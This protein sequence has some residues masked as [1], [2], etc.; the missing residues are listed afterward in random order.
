MQ[1][2]IE[3]NVLLYS[4]LFLG[5]LLGPLLFFT[6]RLCN[7]IYHDYSRHRWYQEVGSFFGENRYLLEGASNILSSWITNSLFSTPV[8]RPFTLR[9]N[10][11]P[12]A[13][14]CPYAQTC[15]GP[16]RCPFSDGSR[17]VNA[18]AEPRRPVTPDFSLDGRGNNRRP[19][20]PDFSINPSEWRV[21]GGTSGV[22]GTIGASGT[23][24]TTGGVGAAAS[25]T[26]CDTTTLLNNLI[27]EARAIIRNNEYDS[28]TD[29]TY[30]SDDSSKSDV[31]RLRDRI[32][33]CFN[34]DRIMR[35]ADSVDDPNR[36]EGDRP[37]FDSLSTEQLTETSLSIF[38]RLQNNDENVILNTELADFLRMLC[39]FYLGRDEYNRRYRENEI[40]SDIG[41]TRER[42]RTPI[43]V[44]EP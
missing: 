3:S 39:H 28:D 30:S 25:R 26:R 20:T 8:Y 41:E 23:S 44:E 34:F 35:L 14:E 7:R 10:E 33:R 40:E 17:L 13:Q 43:R 4:F 16:L 9:K 22:T 24:G 5:S 31:S 29:S 38:S 36:S 42:S 15:P 18:Y 6:Y 2:V 21:I 12:F 37:N 32:R 19:V 1:F 11:C 27:N